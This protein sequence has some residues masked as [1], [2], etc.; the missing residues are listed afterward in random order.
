M[1]AR[2]KF[3]L[4]AGGV[5]LVLNI[6]VSAGLGICGPV[7]ALLAGAAAGYFAVQQEQIMTKEEGARVGAISGG[8]AGGLVFIGQMIGGL[9]ILL[10]VQ[11]SGTQSWIGEIPNVSASTSEQLL[12]YV[13]G[14]GIGVCFGI[15]GVAAAAAGGAGAG[16][17]GGPASSPG[18][19][20]PEQ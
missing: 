7:V 5:G 10:L 19:A 6:C 9:S 18:L 8:I 16:Y 20:T 12:Y 13:G 17:L 11:S 14:L 4:I 15:V 1:K 3:G 2:V